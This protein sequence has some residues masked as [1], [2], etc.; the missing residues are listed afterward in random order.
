MLLHCF[1]H[2]DLSI[3]TYLIGDPKSN[4][5]AVI[6][7]VRNIEPVIEMIMAKGYD[8]LY[9]L[10]THVHA[11]FVSGSKELKL[12][13]V[14]PSICC[15]KLG[16]PEWIP[17]YAD[18]LIADGDEIS[19]G[20]CHLKSMHTPGHTPEHIIWLGF[21]DT[22]SKDVPCLAFTGDLLFVGSVGRPDLLGAESFK[23]LSNELY[24]SLFERL[25]DLPSFLEIYP[26]H[27]AGSLC[28]KSISGRASST[29]GYERLFNAFLLQKPEQQWIADLQMEMP[30]A[31]ESFARIKQLN[32]Q[33]TPPLPDAVTRPKALSNREVSEAVQ[34]DAFII[35]VRDPEVFAAKHLK[36]SVNVFLCDS[37]CNWAG[38]V[39]PADKP[40]IIILPEERL[41]KRVTMQLGMIGL[42]NISGYATWEQVQNSGSMDALL[43]Q[44]V[45]ALA[46]VK[47]EP[48]QYILDVRTPAEWHSGHI[49]NAHHIELAQLP[50]ALSRIPR[51]KTITVTCGGGFRASA[52]AS[53]LRREGFKHVANLKGGMQAWRAANL[54]TTKEKA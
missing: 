51:D 34:A 32:V 43:L 46:E 21:D 50:S 52:A 38:M 29:W 18:K 4:Q 28:S 15:S 11:D 54:P 45:E 2:P 19:L 48:A 49:D 13:L 31:P 24:K 5:F 17:K 16:G 9:I 22:R 30:A 47:N 3:N 23:R 53:L 36:N 20:A 1:H 37:F 26:A 14:T 40:L 12:H 7:P 6:D 33:G 41:A 8:V 35:D 27:G 10:E 39:T 44:S 25:K 42:D